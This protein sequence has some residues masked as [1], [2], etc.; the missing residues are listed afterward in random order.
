MRA[1]RTRRSLS[2]VA[3]AI[4]VAAAG[5]F[6]AS[7]SLFGGSSAAR[8]VS[9]FTLAVG[10][11]LV[12]P[13]KVQAD[14]TKIEVVPC[15]TGH[16]QEVYA[17][18][19]DRAGSTYP[20][21]AKLDSFANAACLDHFAG[22]VGIPYQQSSL[23]FTYLLPSVRSWADGDRTV[24]CVAETTGRSLTKSIQGAKI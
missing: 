18:A 21:S 9:V 12:P 8:Q 7:C 20:T 11:C 17:L 16:T 5:S 22:Y 19:K 6:G 23:F 2:T 4:V 1:L 10:Q 24:V 3:V 14:L 13:K 15:T